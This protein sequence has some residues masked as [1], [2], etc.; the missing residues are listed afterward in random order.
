MTC[1]ISN[2]KVP[3]GTVKIL[4]RNL[5]VKKEFIGSQ[6]E[7]YAIDIEKSTVV[8][9]GEDSELRFYNLESSSKQPT[10]VVFFDLVRKL[11]SFRFVLN[12]MTISEV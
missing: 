3:S 8:C 7:T 11:I 12:M 10:K 2:G 5:E 4:D 6:E 9:G 1:S